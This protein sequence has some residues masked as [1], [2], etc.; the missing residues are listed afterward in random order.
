MLTLNEITLYDWYG[1]FLKEG[2]KY[3]VDDKNDGWIIKAN[4]RIEPIYGGVKEFI[5]KYAVDRRKA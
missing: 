4:G 2:V 3:F 1:F 5:L